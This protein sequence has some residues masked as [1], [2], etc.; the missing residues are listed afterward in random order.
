MTI[1]DFNDFYNPSIKRRNLASVEGVEIVGEVP[2]VRPYLHDADIAISPLKLARGIQ[3]KVL[4]AMACGLPTVVS[5]QS[6]EGINATSGC[7][8]LIADSESKWIQTIS[9]LRMSPDQQLDVGREAR[10]LVEVHYC[11]TAKLSKFID[12]IST[13]DANH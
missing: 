1:D 9:N 4:E 7:E 8:L 6:A 13:T 11:W 2:D 5:P 3:N 12:A 10:R